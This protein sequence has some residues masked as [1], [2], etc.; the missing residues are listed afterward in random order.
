MA[1][2]VDNTARH[3]QRLI[4]W[5]VV[6]VPLGWGVYATLQNALQLFR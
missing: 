6:S 1:A 4:R 3:S 2:T 5:L